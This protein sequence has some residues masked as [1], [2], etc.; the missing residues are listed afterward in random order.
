METQATT[1]ATAPITDANLDNIQAFL[2]EYASHLEQGTAGEFLG[3]SEQNYYE[4]ETLAHK[5]YVQQRYDKATVVLEGLVSLSEAR[6]YPFLLFGEVLMVQGNLDEALT[7]LEKAHTLDKTSV[8]VKLKL[9]ELYVK[10]QRNDEAA[11]LLM[12]IL[13]VEGLEGTDYVKQQRARVIMH[14]L[15]EAHNKTARE[16]A[17][18]RS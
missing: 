9:A 12:E 16:E 6:A 8:G 10:Q 17:A 18:N 7:C 1:T 4:L 14:A 5:F 15:T 11:V 3:F 2:S 13:E